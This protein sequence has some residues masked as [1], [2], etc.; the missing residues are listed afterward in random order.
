MEQSNTFDFITASFEQIF[1]EALRIAKES[2]TDAGSFFRQ[3][4]EY[5]LH[6]AIDVSTMEE[7]IKRAKSNFG[8]H[9]ARFDAATMDLIYEVYD[10]EHP[11]FG[12]RPYGLTS[13]QIYEMGQHVAMKVK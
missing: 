2:P 11:Y 8:Y 7:A 9:A 5:I 4:A 1:D 6:D 12:K 13:Q 10:C 3:Y